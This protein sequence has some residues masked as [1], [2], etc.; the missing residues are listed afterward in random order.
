MKESYPPAKAVLNDER[1]CWEVANAQC[2][3]VDK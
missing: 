1:R 3:T 2:I